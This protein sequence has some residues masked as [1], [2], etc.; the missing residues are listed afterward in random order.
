MELMD[1]VGLLTVT[2]DDPDLLASTVLVAF[3]VTG[4][5]VGGAT[6]AV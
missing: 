1:G 3:T 6:G 4:L 2:A 5:G